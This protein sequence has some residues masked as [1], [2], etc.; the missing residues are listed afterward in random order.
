MDKKATCKER[1]PKTWQE[2]LNKASNLLGF[3]PNIKR[4][5][6]GQNNAGQNLAKE[7]IL[8]PPNRECWE[9]PVISSTPNGDLHGEKHTIQSLSIATRGGAALDVSAISNIILKEGDPPQMVSTEVFGP[10]PQGTVRL[11]LGR[12]SLIATYTGVID[13]DY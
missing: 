8:Y 6:M 10:L 12:S 3:V 4:D 1:A 5:F 9:G 7:E 13:S 2:I 11:I